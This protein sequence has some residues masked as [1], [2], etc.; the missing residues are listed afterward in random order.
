MLSCKAYM[1]SELDLPEAVQHNANG[2]RVILEVQNGKGETCQVTFRNNEDGDLVVILKGWGNKPRSI[3]NWD[4]TSFQA[5]IPFEPVNTCEVCGT[6]L[7]YGCGCRS[8]DRQYRILDVGEWFH[9]D[10]QIQHEDGS[11]VG[12]NRT[13][14]EIPDDGH[15]YRRKI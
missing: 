9:H 8:L 12:T 3:G 11:W 13:G 6:Q 2:D 4:N 15:R 5:T 10:D 14:Q 1:P 7:K